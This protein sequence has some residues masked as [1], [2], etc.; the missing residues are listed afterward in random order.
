LRVT[1]DEKGICNAIDKHLTGVLQVS[2]WN[3]IINATKLQLRR[4]GAKST[5]I[6]V[7]VS[8][9]QELFC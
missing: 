7:H 1:D 8:K 3:Y 2:C 6:L 9:L 4:Y 5:E